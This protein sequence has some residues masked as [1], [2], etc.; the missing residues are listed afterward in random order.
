MINAMDVGNLELAKMYIE[1]GADVNILGSEG[2]T[3]LMLAAGSGDI[4]LTRFALN[5]G[6]NINAIDDYYNTPLGF[7]LEY[8]DDSLMSFFVN[9]GA[10]IHI[11]DKEG[12]TL[13]MNKVFNDYE[14]RASKLLL[15]Y[16]AD[17]NARNYK[18]Q[19]A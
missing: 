6:A 16:G 10:N 19:T 8:M 9:H 13:F 12:N 1:Q 3:F 5:H 11:R 14:F 4:E 15:K 17:M 2:A 7:A 18:G